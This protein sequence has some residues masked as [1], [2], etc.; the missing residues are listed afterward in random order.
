MLIR[1][2]ILMFTCF[3]MSLLA[4]AHHPEGAGILVKGKVKSGK[5]LGTIKDN[6]YH[7]PGELYTIEIPPATDQGG[8]IEDNYDE[9][10]SAGVVF[11]NDFGF[12]L[13]LEFD[14][15]PLEVTS[16]IQQF[17]EIKDEVLDAIF[18]DVMLNQ[19]KHAIH[20]TH[21][22]HEEKL[23]LDNGE[24]ALF[25]VL[26]MPRSATLSDMKTGLHLDAKRGY[27][28][29]FT[30]SGYL[31]NI[32]MQDT[33]SLIPSVKEAAKTRLKERLL[34]NLLHV[35]RTCKSDELSLG[36]SK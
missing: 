9:G 27:L 20:G 25:V 7:S 32:S 18:F 19:I 13:K 17:P 34:N 5:I 16:I 36:N 28:F 23:T 3:S 24:P 33:I 2:C 11:F 31:I 30:K 14:A 21:V 15:L 35:Q 4:N 22:L 12:L 6:V 1:H 29:Y 10:D 26:D 8:Y